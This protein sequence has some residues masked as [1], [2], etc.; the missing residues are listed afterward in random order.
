VVTPMLAKDG[1]VYVLNGV[2]LLA[3]SP[4]GKVLATATVAIN[5]GVESSPT[6]APDGTVY[7]AS[8][9]GKIMAFAGTHGGLMDSPWPKFQGGLSNSGRA[10]TF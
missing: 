4:E 10:R 9:E 3:V 5:G 6:L 8:L 2:E 1:T 7:V